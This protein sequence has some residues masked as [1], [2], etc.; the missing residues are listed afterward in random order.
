VAHDPAAVT[1]EQTQSSEFWDSFRPSATN[2]G[3]AAAFVEKYCTHTDG[4]LLGEPFLLEPWQRWVLDLMFEVDPETGLRRWREFVLVIPRG[5]GKSALV[6]ALGFYLLCM[7]GE[8]APEVYSS[9][10]GEDQAKAVFEPAKLMWDASPR[11]QAICQKYSKAFVAKG[12]KKGYWNLVS[13]VAHTKQGKKT[14]ALLNDEYHVHPKPDLRDTFIKGMHKRKQALAIDVTT[15]GIERSGPLEDL[16]RGFRDAVELGHGSIEQVHEFLQVFRTS[17]KIM[18]R[19]GVPRDREEVV[20]FDD[21]R[22]I[23]LC[24]PLSVIHPDG[25]IADEAPPQPGKKESEFRVYHMNDAVKD[26]GGEGIP[27]ELW[28]ACADP[29]APELVDGQDVVLG[30]DAG[31]RKDCSA[32]VIA[33]FLPDGRARFDAEIWRPPREKGL[34]LDLE[35]TLHRAVWDAIERYNV[36]RI[37]GDPALLNTLFQQLQRRVGSQVVREYRFAWGDTGPDSVTL[38]EALVPDRFVHSGDATYKRHMMNLRTR[39]GP[40]GAWRWDDH[41]DKPN[42]HSDVPNDAGIATMMAAGE[43]LGGEQQ[44]QYA[45]RGLIIA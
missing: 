24:N 4:D 45:S 33:G 5:N 19:W 29:S 18:V 25:L 32:V 7:D 20:A 38:L 27:E 22:A 39:F 3:H 10:W 40:N 35:A 37:V 1:W 30:L 6:S 43:L 9:A 13:K 44:N 34:E 28:D 26:A 12:A 36:K 23:R 8:G 14:H 16:Q 31:Y 41:P 2:G 15:E 11:L 21:V 17:R 42:E